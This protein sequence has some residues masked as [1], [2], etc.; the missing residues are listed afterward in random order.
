ME[1]LELTEIGLPLMLGVETSPT[2]SGSKSF[3][4]SSFTFL[5]AKGFMGSLDCPGTCSVYLE[6]TL[7]LPPKC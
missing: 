4:F 5:E 2:M 1:G 6:V 3:L 7:P